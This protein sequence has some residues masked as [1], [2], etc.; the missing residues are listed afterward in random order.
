MLKDLARKWKFALSAGLLI[1]AVFLALFVIS[2]KS[3]VAIVSL[4]FDDASNTQYN[5]GFQI[6]QK[7]GLT[8]TLFVATEMVNLRESG[9]DNE[10]TMTW[11]NIRE[12]QAAGWEIGSHSRTHNRLSDQSNAQITDELRGSQREIE[13]KTGIS[14]VSFSSPF[15]NFTEDI[16]ARVMEYYD[17]HLSWKGHRGR[18][19]AARFDPSYIGRLEVTNDMTPAQV[20]GEMVRAAESNIWLVVLFHGIVDDEAGEYEVS[21]EIYEDILSCTKI[22]QDNGL[23]QVETVRNAAQRLDR[24]R[25]SLFARPPKWLQRGRRQ[26]ED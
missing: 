18:N 23:I 6:A 16:I 19:P 21:A 7:Y 1:V 14:P 4:T 25:N 11:D 2:S 8:G 9:T 13:A 17:Y 22:L 3:S 12:I 5:N 10:W 26:A 15:G 24:R 20:C